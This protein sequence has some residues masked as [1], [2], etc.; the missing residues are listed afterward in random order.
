MSKIEKKFDWCLKKG[1]GD[2]HK[3]IVKIEPDKTSSKNHIDKALH[4]LKAFDHNKESFP[5]W[6]ISAAFYTMYHSFLAI[7]FR[8][9]YE[10]RNQECT[11][12]AIEYFIEN[13]TIALDRKCVE[14]ARRTSEMLPTDAKS[15]REEFQYGT[16]T[17]VDD[18]ILR[19]LR[20]N[21]VEVLE[22]VQI[23]LQ[24]LDTQA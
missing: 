7:L 9:G 21:A 20:E 6:A 4:N 5:D 22:S 17:S 2:K 16:E 8:L 1:I 14:M 13:K 24:N 15:L 11:I 3:G 19:N 12:N 18:E 10:S 23:C